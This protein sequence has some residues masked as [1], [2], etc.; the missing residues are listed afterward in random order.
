SARARLCF[1]FQ[2]E[3]SNRSAP[4]TGVQTCA[5]PIYF[6]APAQDSLRPNQFG[7]TAGGPIVKDKLFLFPGYQAT[8]TRTA[9]PQTISYVPTKSEERR[10]GREGRSRWGP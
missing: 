4:V 3:H 9:P 2:A 6:L 1:F 10:V 5:L 7:G 8:R